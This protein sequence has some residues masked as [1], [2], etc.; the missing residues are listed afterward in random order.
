MINSA[1]RARPARSLATMIL[2]VAV[3][4]GDMA[5]APPP[6]QGKVGLLLVFENSIH[7]RSAAAGAGQSNRNG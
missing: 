3:P 1:E 7:I 4:V 5:Y 6:G 2:A